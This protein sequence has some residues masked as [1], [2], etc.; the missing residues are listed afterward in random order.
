[1]STNFAA[2]SILFFNWKLFYQD[3]TISRFLVYRNEVENS[4]WTWAAEQKTHAA[5]V[6][7]VCIIPVG[8]FGHVLF[9]N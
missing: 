2:N 7:D 9:I 4:K 1:M 8:E 6:V 3:L 5:Q